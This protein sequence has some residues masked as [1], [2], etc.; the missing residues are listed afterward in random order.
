[1]PHVPKEGFVS[2]VNLETDVTTAPAALRLRQ[3]REAGRGHQDGAR[4]GHV[5]PEQYV[6]PP[7]PPNIPDINPLLSAV[8]APVPAPLVPP[9]VLCRSLSYAHAL[10]PPRK[11]ST[12]GMVW[13]L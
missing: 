12:D 5:R 4:A 2:L 13:V 11:S 10:Y 9:L 6:V 8:D 1:M 7:S 3:D